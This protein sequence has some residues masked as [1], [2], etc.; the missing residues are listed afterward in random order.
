MNSA[1]S[2]M[3]RIIYVSFLIAILSGCGADHGDITARINEK[4]EY[5]DKLVVAEI[6]R[7][8]KKEQVIKWLTEKGRKATYVEEDNLVYSM[9]D[10]VPPNSLVCSEWKIIL[11]IS[12]N[13]N[14]EYENHKFEQVGMCL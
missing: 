4:K 14:L 9:V 11:E 3:M 6:S 2:E 8:A 5:W 1:L 7:N 10:V 13:E 12:L